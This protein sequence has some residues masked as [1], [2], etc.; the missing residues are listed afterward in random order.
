[1][2]IAHDP[3]ASS[4]PHHIQE[5]MISQAIAENMSS[6][7]NLQQYISFSTIIRHAEHP[8]PVITQWLQ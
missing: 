3:E 6:G 4:V 5:K 1:M 2:T 7:H 8:I